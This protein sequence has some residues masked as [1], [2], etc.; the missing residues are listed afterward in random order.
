MLG[1]TGMFDRSS[2]PHSSPNK[3]G[4]PKTK[5]IVS[6]RLRKRWGAVRLGAETGVA[7]STAGAVLHR[8]GI[9]HPMGLGVKP[10]P[11]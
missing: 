1:R 9:R 2:R 3:I 10:Q 4:A 11:R 5:R 8:C 6:L 7:P